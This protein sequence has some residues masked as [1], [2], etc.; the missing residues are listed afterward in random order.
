MFQ[1]DTLESQIQGP[2]NSQFL[3]ETSILI[4][5]SYQ[6]TFLK[7]KLTD[8]DKVSKLQTFSVLSKKYEL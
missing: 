6:R 7:A 2:Y 5:L 8:I 1:P 4:I 3:V